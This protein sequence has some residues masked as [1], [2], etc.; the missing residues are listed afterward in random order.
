[1]NI[2]TRGETDPAL[3]K[4]Y[5][6]DVTTVLEV[7]DKQLSENEYVA[8]KFSLVDILFTPYFHLLMKVRRSC[9]HIQT[10]QNGNKK[11]AQDQHG[12]R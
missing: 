5:L 12:R 6:T 1:M 7:L 9:Y 2:Q 8:G 4:Q 10:L 3:C 11:L